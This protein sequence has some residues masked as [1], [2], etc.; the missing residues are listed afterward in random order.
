MAQSRRCHPGVRRIRIWHC[1]FEIRRYTLDLGWFVERGAY[2]VLV[3][4][5]RVALPGSSSY[6]VGRNVGPFHMRP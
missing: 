3:V 1:V 4:Q 2:V 6:L 5:V